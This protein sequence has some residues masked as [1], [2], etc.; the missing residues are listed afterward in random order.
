VPLDENVVIDVRLTPD[1]GLQRG[2]VESLLCRMAQGLEEG[3]DEVDLTDW[4]VNRSVRVGET[5]DAQ[6]QRNPIG[7]FQEDT[8]SQHAKIPQHV[9]MIAGE[10]DNRVVRSLN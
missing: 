8:F 4:I 10:G 7:G 9:S 5:G 6:E 2:A 1:G 3:R